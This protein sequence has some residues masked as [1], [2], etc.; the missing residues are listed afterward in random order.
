MKTKGNERTFPPMSFAFL[1]LILFIFSTKSSEVRNAALRL[2][3]TRPHSWGAGCPRRGA[4]ARRSDQPDL[5]STTPQRF[6]R[7]RRRTLVSDEHVDLLYFG[8][9]GDVAADELGGVRDDHDLP[10]HSHHLGVELSLLQMRCHDTDLR[11]QAI[12][13]QV[14]AIGL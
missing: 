13:T 14:Q 2:P 12:R 6:D 5:D 9:E 7:G 10:G 1:L 11:V 3:R 4:R 8:D